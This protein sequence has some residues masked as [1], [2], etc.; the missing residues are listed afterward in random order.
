M[1]LIKRLWD[2]FVDTLETIAVALSLFVVIY[3]TAAQPHK[4]QGESMMPN[5][6]NGNFLLTDKVSYRFHEPKR[7]DVVVFHYPNDRRYDYIKR[8]IGLPGEKIKIE[9]NQITIYNEEHPD[10]FVLDEPYIP[11]TM[12]TLGKKFASPGKIVPIPQG[13]YFVVG[14]NREA[15]SDSREWGPVGMDDVVGRAFFVYWPPE[16]LHVVK[17]LLN[18]DAKE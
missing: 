7:G 2:F 14:D 1:D 12:T 13:E 16:R 5:F 9:D 15:S 11:D 8:V 6:Q 4:V 18:V 10:G 3:A 17:N